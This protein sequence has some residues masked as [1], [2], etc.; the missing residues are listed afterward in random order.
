MTPTSL[1]DV[2]RTRGV[3]LAINADALTIDAPKGVLTN[4]LRRAIRQ[5]KAAL[6]ALVTASTA[7]ASPVSASLSPTYPCVVCGQTSRWDDHG[8]WRCVT[9][10]PRVGIRMPQEP[11]YERTV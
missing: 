3:L 2:L 8:I 11:Q 1:L 5:H 4:E 7:D 9:C 6:L 10:W